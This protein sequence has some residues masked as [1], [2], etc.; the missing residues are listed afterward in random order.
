MAIFV[1]LYFD[2]YQYTMNQYDKFLLSVFMFTTSIQL[3][4]QEVIPLYPGE[5]PNSTSYKMKEI[6]ITEGGGKER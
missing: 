5:I 4:A 1:A 6:T 3:V 2:K